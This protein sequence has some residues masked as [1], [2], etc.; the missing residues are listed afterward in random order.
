MSTAI[1]RSGWRANTSGR[2]GSAI[3]KGIGISVA[4]SLVLILA[5][6]GAAAVTPKPFQF[7]TATHSARNGTTTD[8]VTLDKQTCATLGLGVG[9]TLT[10]S[11]TVGIAAP[12]ATAGAG[13]TP[14][15]SSGS[16]CLPFDATLSYGWMGITTMSDRV[17]VPVCWNG[18][19]TWRNGSGP[20]CYVY[21]PPGYSF[22]VDWCG[23][24]NNNTTSAQAGDNW[25]ISSAW[26]TTYFWARVNFTGS[27]CTFWCG[28]GYYWTG[29]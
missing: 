26:S 29:G 21:P 23:M 10:V 19:T 7:Q 5:P 22:T 4:A 17:K 20:D 3:R 6:G 9:C 14:M 15:A 12:L 28:L 27:S 2:V 13:I 16:G 11:T 25:H 24:Y 8:V 18:P 1:G